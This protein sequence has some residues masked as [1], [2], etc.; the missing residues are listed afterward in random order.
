[1]GQ[2]AQSLVT[3]TGVFVQVSRVKTS[4]EFLGG[5][6]KENLTCIKLLSLAVAGEN[7][8]QRQLMLSVL[9]QETVNGICLRC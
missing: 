8:L 6:S 2:S 3:E 4:R 7:L 5:L 1:M 9:E